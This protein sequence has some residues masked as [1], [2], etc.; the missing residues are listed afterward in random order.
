MCLVLQRL[1]RSHALPAWCH[2]A[3]FPASG[4]LKKKEH[5]DITLTLVFTQPGT[6]RNVFVL[7]VE[8]SG[9]NQYLP[10]EV[11][12]MIITNHFQKGQGDRHFLMREG[13]RS[14]KRKKEKERSAFIHWA[15]CA[16][17]F[18]CLLRV[19]VRI[20]IC[21]VGNNC[22]DNNI[23]IIIMTFNNR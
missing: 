5:I 13:K 4:T 8:G 23:M 7:S 6:M 12:I 21:S 16:T 15:I 11:M 18:C 22:H 20:S 9:A 2:F 3:A 14:K 19:A 10:V 17:Y 1:E